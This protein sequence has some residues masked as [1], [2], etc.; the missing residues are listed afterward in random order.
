MEARVR[1]NHPACPASDL[2]AAELMHEAARLDQ[3][4]Q[5]HS[6]MARPSRRLTVLIIAA[7]IYLA[8]SAGLGVV[9]GEAALHPPRRAFSLNAEA[10]ARTRVE[11]IGG[12]LDTA[13]ITTRDGVELRAWLFSPPASKWNGH[14]VLSLHGVADNRESGA[15]M[16]IQLASHGYR[17]LTPDARASGI[18]GGAYATYGVLERDD[19]REWVGWL[20]A[21]QPGGCVHGMGGSMGAAHLLQAIRDPALFCD[22]VVESSFASFREVAFD[23]V[24]QPLG[25]G[26]WLGRTLL[27]PAI[28]AGFLSAR[29]RTGL[30]LVDADPARVL[31]GVTTPVLLIHGLADRNMPLRHAQALAASN[32]DHVTL[33]LV[34]NAT[35]T[36]AWAAAPA[37]YPRRVL[38]FFAAHEGATPKPMNF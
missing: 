25:T 34:A 24:G 16:A 35:H 5:E 11:S 12:H 23:R 1:R 27:R 8:V 15:S 7:A 31:R 14:A 30:N 37:D 19:V 29:L 10:R 22:A 13:T 20:R 2:S 32:P 18:S 28:E 38:D 26:P 9:L 17:V 6:R 4:E 36:A 33:W 21:R 3:Q